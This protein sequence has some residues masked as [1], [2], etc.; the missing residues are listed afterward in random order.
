MT[1][2]RLPGMPPPMP[3]NRAP[4]ATPAPAIQEVIAQMSN[5]EYSDEYTEQTEIDGPHVAHKKWLD[6]IETIPFDPSMRVG[7]L[8]E[9]TP[10]RAVAP[11]RVDA[12]RRAQ[13]TP[14]PAQRTPAPRPRPPTRHPGDN[15]VT[16]LAHVDVAGGRVSYSPD[17]D[18]AAP[19]PSIPTP[20]PRTMMHAPYGAP[21]LPPH[22]PTAMALPP[23]AV[24]PTQVAQPL[25]AMATHVARALPALVRPYQDGVTPYPV[26][27]WATGQHAAVQAPVAPPVYAIPQQHHLDI[28]A[29]TD[30]HPPL[31]ASGSTPMP[32]VPSVRPSITR[33]LLPMIGGTALLVFVAGYFLVRGDTQRAAPVAPV[34]A[35]AVPVKAPAPV[36]SEIVEPQLPDPSWKHRDAQPTIVAKT[37]PVV[38]E[39]I[40][41]PAAAS[42]VSTTKPAAKAKVKTKA[43]AKLEKTSSARRAKRAQVAA[44]ELPAKKSAKSAEKTVAKTKADRDPILEEIEK[45]S[46]S[47]QTK[48][49]P[50]K[51]AIST[52]V[53]TLI[54][55][56]G[57]STNLMT[58]KTLNLPAGKHKITLLELKSRK[59][60][61]IDVDIAAGSIAKLDKTF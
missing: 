17:P 53:P 61:T 18:Q 15:A 48:T 31:L 2:K 57:R 6:S 22:V 38:V 43:K 56:D 50:G 45:P 40:A 28:Y 10:P 32:H 59:A 44:I 5:L 58:P 42:E 30:E 23:H 14:R 1:A 21:A 9:G 13:G 37:E 24:M 52:S 47:A 33:Y 4:A 34:A 25:A 46:K 36:V 12:P 29:D 51:L 35:A 16:R 8:G 26:P 54:Y 11:V 27:P 41:M 49:G 60:K 19:L 55:V 3:R 39:E 7:D 20:A